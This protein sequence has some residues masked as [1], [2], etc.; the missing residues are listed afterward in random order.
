MV[1]ICLTKKMAGWDTGLLNNGN[2][3]QIVLPEQAS[4][5]FDRSGNLSIKRLGISQLNIID[6]HHHQV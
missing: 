4:Q 2:I 1:H 6:S 5:I 3:L